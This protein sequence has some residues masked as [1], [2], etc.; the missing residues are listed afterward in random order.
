MLLTRKSTS[1]G[2]P[3][4]SLVAGLSRG[5][6]RAIPALDRRT[7]L[8]RSG[9]GLGAG[10]AASQLLLVRK[11]RAADDAKS[12]GTK[13]VEVK[14]TV[15]GHCSVGC[16]LDAVV[17]N[18]V[19]VRH[20]PVFDS[21]Q[22]H[23]PVAPL[24]GHSER[25]S[26]GAISAA[27]VGAHGRDEL[28]GVARAFDDMADRVTALLRAGERELLANVSHELRTPLARIRVALDLA[29]EGDAGVARELL[30]D[31][32]GDLDELER[33]ISDILTAARLDLG[34]GSRRGDPAAAAYR[35]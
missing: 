31:I 23:A 32:A 6:A 2:A 17:E 11:A 8:R 34:D 14:R 33:L 16:A 22:P 3:S 15:C 24:F 28:G 25:V 5:I 30:P 20:E 1:V 26:A 9:L 27:R 35:R 29:L 4:S 21:P 13:K 7:F 12:D 10:M 18:G 19:W